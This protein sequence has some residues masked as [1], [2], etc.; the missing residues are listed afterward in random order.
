MKRRNIGTGT[1]WEDEV[2][3]SRAVKTGGE[4]HVSGTTATSH[5]GTIV[6]LGDPYRQTKQILSNIE[7]ALSELD[8]SLTDIVRTRIY[9][10]DIED[11]ETVG[12]AHGELL[13]EVRPAT[14]MVEVEQLIEPELLVEIEAVARVDT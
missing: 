4:I 3:Y 11:W 10:V 6:G 5:D 12:R 7:D 9:V 1:T 2:G 14:T 13:G 8:A